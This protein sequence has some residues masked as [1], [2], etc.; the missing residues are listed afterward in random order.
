MVP[1]STVLLYEIPKKCGRTFGT[2]QCIEAGGLRYMLAIWTLRVVL[3]RFQM[4]MKN[5]SERWRK[6]DPV[7][8]WQGTWLVHVLVFWG[9]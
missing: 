6:D 2:G 7:K 1:S 4:E 9:R 5:I 3:V 8:K